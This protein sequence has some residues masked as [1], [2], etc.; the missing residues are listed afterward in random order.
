M[1]ISKFIDKLKF[2]NHVEI[3]Y[4]FSVLLFLSLFRKLK[5]RSYLFIDIL[6]SIGNY[7]LYLCVLL[8]III[9]FIF[10]KKK[11]IPIILIL[12]HSIFYFLLIFLFE[13]DI[14]NLDIIYI[15]KR[16]FQIFILIL[17]FYIALK[18]KIT[19]TINLKL[20][21]KF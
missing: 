1:K 13:D 14:L 19:L 15:V 6:S 11:I 12:T 16:N 4:F 17:A 18:T 10:I 7:A 20:C 3:S 8:L 2:F 5:S 9:F 21:S